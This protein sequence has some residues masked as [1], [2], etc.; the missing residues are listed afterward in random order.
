[1]ATPDKKWRP[2][3]SFGLNI[4][5]WTKGKQTNFTFQRSYM[6]DGERKYTEFMSAGDIL[7][8]AA[9]APEL[10]AYA[11]RAADTGTAVTPA[12]APAQQP[13]A[14]D[15]NEDPPF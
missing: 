9:L 6:K 10:V 5:A 7:A 1:M 4:S 15:D 2:C 11:Q 14:F 13:K 12:A 3:S 8:I